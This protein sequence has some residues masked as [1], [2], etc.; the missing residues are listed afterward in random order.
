MGLSRTTAT[1][2]LLVAI[3]LL[4][5]PRT[6]LA[7]SAI[8]GQVKD[9]TGAV[10]PGVS[11]DAASPA[12]IEGRRTVVTDG[13]GRF[14]LVNLRPGAYTVTFTLE[15]FTRIVREGIQLQSNF[16]A[17]VDATLSLGSLQ[18]SVTVTGASPVVD[19][20][21]AQR[22]QVLD[23]KL[24]EGIVNSGSLWSQANFVSGVR[25]SGTDVG[26]SQYFSDLQSNRTA[27]ARCTTPT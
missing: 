27:P 17:T 13:E 24:I 5:V 4:L 22:S 14:T 7:Q 25:M 19:V 8:A 16:T 18:E 21:Q 2:V 9:N 1:A 23:S 12:L 15:G 6:T 10:L 11:V 26:G 3:A 20:Q